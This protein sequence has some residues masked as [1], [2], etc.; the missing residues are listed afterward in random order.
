M[1]YLFHAVNITV[2]AYPQ[3]HDSQ[4][5]VQLF[6]LQRCHTPRP[7]AAAC[8]AAAQHAACCAGLQPSERLDRPDSSGKGL[9]GLAGWGT[10]AKQLN[11]VAVGA[12]AECNEKAN[13]NRDLQMLC[14]RGRFSPLPPP[15]E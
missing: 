10:R 9:A 7:S 14:K 5:H 15:P 8:C 1:S 12:L 3:Y 6:K 11:L 4:Q 2:A 13:L